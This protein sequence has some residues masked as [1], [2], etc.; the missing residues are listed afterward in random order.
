[1]TQEQKHPLAILAAALSGFAPTD[2]LAAIGGLQLMPENANRAYRLET[3]AHIVASLPDEHGKPTISTPRLKAITNAG[4]L[5]DLA[6]KEDPCDNAFTEAFSFYG[7]SFTVF[8]GIVENPTF[9]LRNLANALFRSTEPV[10]NA[11]FASRARSVIS[12]VLAISD[13]IAFRAGLGRGV[14]PRSKPRGP[15]HYPHAQR[16]AQLKRAVTFT[17]AEIH[18]LLAA[19]GTDISAIVNLVAPLGGIDVEDFS[20]DNTPLLAK[21][22]VRAGRD[23]IVAL[24]SLLLPAARNEIIRHAQELGINDELA[25][26]YNRAVWNTVASSL[27][28]L[29]NVPLPYP[30]PPSSPHLACFQDGLFELDTDKMIYVSLVSDPLTDYDA[31]RPY[32]H[33]DAGD[34][35]KRLHRRWQE[36]EAVILGS[37]YPPNEILRLVI[38]SGVGRSTGLGFEGPTA[39][40]KSLFIGMTASDLDTISWLEI[41]DPLA[42]WKFAE[43]HSEIR[44]ETFVLTTGLL[45]E[46][47]LYRSRDYSYYLSDERRYTS[48]FI[49]PGGAGELRREVLRE[50]DWH[51][52]PSYRSGYATEVTALFDTGS[53]PVYLAQSTIAGGQVQVLVEGLPLP[54]WIVGEHYNSE[55]QHSLHSLYGQ[56][57]EAIGYWLWQFTTDLGPRLTPLAANYRRIL[58][59]ISLSPGEGWD[60]DVDVSEGAEAPIEVTCNLKSGAVHITLRPHISK[61][62][63][64]ADNAGERMMM[65]HILTGLRALLPEAARNALNDDEIAKILD[66]YAPLGIKKKLLFLTSSATLELDRDGLPP[67][68][69][70]QKADENRLLDE[71][72]RYLTQDEGLQIGPLPDAE[73][74]PIL[75]KVVDY[76]YRE[77]ERLVATLRPDGLLEWL[78][79]HQESIVREAA[80]HKLTIPTRLACFSSEPEMIE[81]LNKE[82]PERASSGVASRF[83]IEYVV[84]R[85]PNGLRPISLSVY[86]RLLALALQI[87]NFAFESDLINH[88]LAD[89]KFEILPSGRLGADRAKF[90]KAHDAYI[91]V[92]SASELMRTRTGFGRH[93]KGDQLTA[94][95]AG[96]DPRVEIATTKEFGHSLSELVSLMVEAANIGKEIDPGIAC[97]PFTELVGRLTSELGWGRDKVTDALNLLS[98]EPRADFLKPP[99]PHRREDVYP[100]RYNRSLSYV[101]RSFLRRER[102]GVEEVLWGTRNLYN[103]W[104]YLVHLC[105]QG[106][107]QAKSVEMRQLI[108]DF[109]IERGKKFNDRVAELFEQNPK[110]I[111]R[112]RVKKVNKHRLITPEGDDL[113]DIDVLTVDARKKRVTAIECKDLAIARTPYEMGSEVKNLFRG[114]ENHKPIVERHQRR[115]EWIRRHLD[116]VLMWLQVSRSGKWKVEGLIVV[117]QV[118]FTPYVY[119]SP[120]PVLS[121]DELAGAQIHKRM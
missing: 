104:N 56:L 86:D 69:K 102:D 115:V 109:N 112:R 68:R 121:L 88:E 44:E 41:A 55:E 4:L 33:W 101:R 111:V 79:L 49:A 51:S 26:H 70:L 19:Q 71:L 65:E 75:R 94:D 60:R 120:I 72:G 54:C 36:V 11:H 15:V 80:F 2:M 46:F 96:P 81:T 6:S 17:E 118:L 32:G 18:E 28:R 110:L 1:M 39:P 3:L 16:F 30:P 76:F 8:P 14:E 52:A 87:V 34:I 113:G 97:L 64:R 91:P 10:A 99:A 13:A 47:H 48:L 38:V 24:P 92:Y 42:L 58:V 61:A 117:D 100:W 9:V 82:L 98:L 77:L 78:V 31:T 57:A 23:F 83:V 22:I 116:D 67:H 119:K 66:K 37:A 35:A 59:R 62:L 107:L 84:A 89:F 5:A 43:A 106:R 25:I 85:P 29:H 95:T 53:I 93:W 74:L 21:P 7:G 73:R 50:R 27:V 105:Q 108:A 63:S 114:H 12:G 20:F 90:E 103:A 45:D 40:A